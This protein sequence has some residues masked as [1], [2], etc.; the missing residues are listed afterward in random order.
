[1]K[2]TKR[3]MP[4][5]FHLLRHAFRGVRILSTALAARFAEMLF[6]TPPRHPIPAAEADA[7]A[8]GRAFRVPFEGSHLAAWAWGPKQGTAPTVIL[9]HGWGGRAGQLRGFIAP[10][11]ESGYR[12]VA[13]DGP[14]HG[15]SGGKQASILHFASALETVVSGTGPVH[16][17]IA[18]SLG[19]AAAAVA[20]S[21]GVEIERVCFIAPPAMA[22]LYY[23]RFLGF[24]GLA[25]RWIAEYS[26]RFA[27]RRGFTWDQLEVPV[28]APG[29][30]SALL[31]FH[32]ADDSDVPFSDGAA[33][34]TSWPGAELHR[35][36][37]LGHRRILKAK[38]VQEKAVAF[39]S[40][41][42][43]FTSCV[44]RFEAELFEPALRAG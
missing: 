36:E 19:C 43:R 22:R 37:G 13:F 31:V 23:E 40:E 7:L 16:G 12:V 28:L 27:A 1:M 33:I 38:D 29:M 6:L 4:L 20:L 34:A 14:A 26:R 17:I 32:D 10:L 5:R 30:R 21:R 41:G 2:K 11:V 25:D 15:A 24:L 35:T 3:A 18:H 8:T 39:L 42:L 9:L 44:Q